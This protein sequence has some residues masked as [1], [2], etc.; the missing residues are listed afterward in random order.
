MTKDE[1]VDHVQMNATWQGYG[2]GDYYGSGS[3]CCTGSG[4]GDGTGMN[5][6]GYGTGYGRGGGTGYGTGYGSGGKRV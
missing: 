2:C 6:T 5:D 4:K 1:F 3:L